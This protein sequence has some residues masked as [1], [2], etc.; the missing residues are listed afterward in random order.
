M[1]L[2]VVHTPTGRIISATQVTMAQ[3][4][5][6][7]FTFTYEKGTQQT[8]ARRQIA[9]LNEDG[10]VNSKENPA[11]PGKFVS[12]FATG[13]GHIPGA[14]ADG[15]PAE[16]L[17]RSPAHLRVAIV[18]TVVEPGPN[19]DY[20]GL[21]P[22]LVGVWQI[23]VRVPELTPPGQADVGLSVNDILGSPPTRQFG[24]LT[25]IWVK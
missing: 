7:I 22:G 20:S 18:P 10:T 8:P 14:P 5:P 19:I 16:G 6:G 3:A 24:F 13:V 2:Q 1:E 11:I 9:A 4:S 17:T 12:L 23:N 21:A 15:S 25:S